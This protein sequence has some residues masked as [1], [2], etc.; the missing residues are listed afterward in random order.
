MFKTDNKIVTIEINTIFIL[1]GRINVVNNKYKF[2]YLEKRE[3]ITISFRCLEILL[4]IL[5]IQQE[6]QTYQG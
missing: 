5:F 4:T 6:N 2:F 3:L 1:D